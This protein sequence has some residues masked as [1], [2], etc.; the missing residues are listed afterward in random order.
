LYISFA[1]ADAGDT[2]EDANFETSVAN[3]AVT[4]LYVEE[5]WV[6]EMIEDNKAGKLREGELT[7]MDRSL[8]FKS[9]LLNL[10]IM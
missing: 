8:S 3:Q 10:C 6:R 5:E 7:F 9:S 1:L 2:M 4:Y